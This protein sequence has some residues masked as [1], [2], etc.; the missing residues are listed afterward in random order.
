MGTRKKR[1]AKRSSI[2]DKRKKDVSTMSITAELAVF[3]YFHERKQEEALKL[4]FDEQTREEYG[5]KLESMG[6]PSVRRMY[7][8]YR[9][10]ELRKENPRT[11]EI[12]KC[13]VCKKDYKSLGHAGDLLH[14]IGT[15]EDIPCPCIIEQ[16]DARLRTPTSV[17]NHLRQK[18]FL[19]VASLSSQEYYALHEVKKDFYKRAE[20][21]RDKYF[22]PEAF[23]RF[24]NSKKLDVAQTLQDPTCK[25][26][27][28]VVKF[29]A[30]RRIHV[31][32]H[33]DLR[34]KCVF[35]GCEFTSVFL[36]DHFKNTHSTKIGDLNETQL[37]EYKE[38]RRKFQEIMKEEMPNYFP[39]KSDVLKEEPS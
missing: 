36:V 7:A 1:V 4:L 9:F 18:H 20:V 3:K 11:V 31:A 25:E 28:K 14:H 24:N 8:H 30:A 5:R 10:N 38:I 12:W 34:W 13:E 19:P 22:P 27:G 16:C 37:F 6:T 21:F 17:R 39:N 32:D 29:L 33:L 15:H 35:E 26:C 2:K 23:V